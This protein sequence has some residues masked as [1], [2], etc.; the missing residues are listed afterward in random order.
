MINGN[1][2][3]RTPVE[4]SELPVGTYHVV[5]SYEGGIPISSNSSLPQAIPQVH[6]GSLVL[7]RSISKPL[8]RV[9]TSI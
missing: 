6:A 2:L 8:R 4:H 5:F 9:A 1:V 3:G 7:A